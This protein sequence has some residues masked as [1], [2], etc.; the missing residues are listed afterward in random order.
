MGRLPDRHLSGVAAAATA[1]GRRS[2]AAVAALPGLQGPG[3]G[4]PSLSPRR[5]GVSA[6]FAE[7]GSSPLV[8]GSLRPARCWWRWGTSAA[9]WSLRVEGWSDHAIAVEFGLTDKLIARAYRRASSRRR[10]GR[11]R[12]WC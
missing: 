12:R 8:R 11:R 4:G 5:R 6:A 1:F 10:R 7:Y 3:M 9:G 2:H